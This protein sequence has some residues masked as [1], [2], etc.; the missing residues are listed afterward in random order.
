MSDLP[1]YESSSEEQ[2]MYVQHRNQSRAGAATNAIVA[3]L[4]SQEEQWRE[5][6]WA[7][8]NGVSNHFFEGRKKFQIS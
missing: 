3:E 2:I 7:Q 8:E 6:H 1:D 5:R 4:R